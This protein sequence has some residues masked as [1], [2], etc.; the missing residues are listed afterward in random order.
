VKRLRRGVVVRYRTLISSRF[1]TDPII[2]RIGNPPRFR[3]PRFR[4]R[5]VAHSNLL[6]CVP[7][8]FVILVECRVEFVGR[9]WAERGKRRSKFKG[10]VGKS[11]TA[12]GRSR[13]T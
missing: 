7:A 13:F 8:R 10:E 11:G 12:S 1:I 6:Q 9:P 5:S 3:L 2:P 4:L